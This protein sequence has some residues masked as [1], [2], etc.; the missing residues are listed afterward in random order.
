MNSPSVDESTGSPV[1]ATLTLSDLD[2]D[3]IRTISRLT[4]SDDEGF[5]YPES[6]PSDA[7]QT[8]DGVIDWA[9][10]FA[11]RSP[12]PFGYCDP[13][14]AILLDLLEGLQEGL[15]EDGGL[16]PADRSAM[17]HQIN[18]LGQALDEIRDLSSRAPP[19]SRSEAPASL[20]TPD[21]L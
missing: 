15:L 2:Y 14:E 4:H 9:R 13:A 6:D 20:V 17:R 1:G 5:D 10:D 8:L 16:S 12:R 3:F 19:L 21:E 18:A 11:S 7:R